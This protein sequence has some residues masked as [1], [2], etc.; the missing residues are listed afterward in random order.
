MNALIEPAWEE[1][2][3]PIVFI[4]DLDRCTPEGTVQLLD[5]VRMLMTTGELNP[6]K[7][8]FVV[9][10]DQT[11]AVRAISTKFAGIR[12]YD[13]NR[14]LEKL[15]PIGFHI[16]PPTVNDSA[17]LIQALSKTFKNLTAKHKDCLVEALT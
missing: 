11:I 12:D 13:G 8:R 4:D 15:F 5:A 14:Y 7:L 10:L 6:L 2:T 9:A 3:T 17:H 1:N 16:P